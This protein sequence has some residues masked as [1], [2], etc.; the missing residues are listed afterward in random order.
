MNPFLRTSPRYGDAAVDPHVVSSI[1]INRHIDIDI[2]IDVDLQTPPIHTHVYYTYLSPSRS[3]YVRGYAF[4]KHVH[5]QT[6][7][8]YRAML[9]AMLTTGFQ[10]THFG[11]AG[12]RVPPFACR[13]R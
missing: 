5:D 11:Q 4:D 2:D 10:A 9:N 8:D 1:L 13:A 12:T 3:S 6:E 7:V